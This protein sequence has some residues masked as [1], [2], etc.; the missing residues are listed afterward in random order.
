MNIKKHTYLGWG[1]WILGSLFFFSE[2]FIR[3]STGVLAP[4]LIE[5]MHVSALSVGSLSAFFYYAYISMQIPVGIIVDIF[6]A[7]W[8]LVVMTLIFGISCIL[9]SY[10]PSIEYGYFYRF[11]MG[12]SGAFAFVGTLKL[13]TVH[14]NSSM[15]ALLAGTT[16]ALGMLGAIVGEAPMSYSFNTFGWRN[17][18]FYLSFVFIAISILLLIVVKENKKELKSIVSLSNIL[19]DIKEV[20]KNKHI[21]LNCLYIGFLY[22]P[23]ATFGEQWGALF[24]SVDMNISVTKGAWFTGFMF[25]GLTIGCPF[26]GFF[27][28]RIKNRLK[29]MRFC[30]VICFF[31]IV[32]IIYHRFFTIEFSPV[33]ISVIMFIYGFFN[34]GIVP[35]YAISTEI[36]QNKV[37]G[38][39]LGIT[40][41][42]SV[43]IGSL[44]IPIIGWILDIMNHHSAIIDKTI[45]LHSFYLAFSPIPVCF[46]ICF[47]L[48]FFIKETHC[49]ALEF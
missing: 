13:I 26:I 25:M 36:V 49:R 7:K 3:V 14:F 38:I 12:F 16:Q 20:L 17:S 44:F 37:A 45:N 23:S 31:C 29:V 18:I 42:A 47:I 5:E 4:H 6:G 22:A 21:W 40:N 32:L 46:I 2:Y 35:S 39:S 11:L 10:M 48:T 41:M 27:S 1:V 43:I 19:K 28:D 15:F 9:F 33:L 8:I 34:G 24:S 30:A